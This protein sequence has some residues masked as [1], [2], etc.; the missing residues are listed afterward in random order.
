VITYVNPV[1]AVILGVIILS[2]RPGTGA[3]AGLLLI[4]AGSWLSTD[5]RLPPGLTRRL[6]AARP[7]VAEQSGVVK[8]VA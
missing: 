2:E 6:R 8:A 4:L 7:A 1:V 5:G 3:V